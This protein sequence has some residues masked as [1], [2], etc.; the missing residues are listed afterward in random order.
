[1]NPKLLGIKISIQKDVASLL[2]KNSLKE[3]LRKWSHLQSQQKKNKIPRK[4]RT[5]VV[6][7]LYTKHCRK[8]FCAHGLEELTLW[9]SHI[10]WSSLQ[11][12]W[13]LCQNPNDNFYRNKRKCKNLYGTTKALGKS[14]SGEKKEI[15]HSLITDYTK[16]SYSKQY[17][18]VLSKK[19][20]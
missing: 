12:L 4:S 9:N 5:K 8:I 20:M 17:S 15:S 13:N 18:T 7:H 3:K 14:N 16:K 2:T 1:M 11:I 6:K 10:T 19:Q